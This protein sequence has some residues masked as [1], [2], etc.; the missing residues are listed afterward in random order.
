MDI[1][2]KRFLIGSMAVA[3]A[4]AR[5]MFAAPAGTVCGTPRMKV[6]VLSDIHV[7]DEATQ[8]VFIKALEW[9]RAQGVDAVLVAGD[10][11]DH[12]LVFQLQLVADAW[13]KVFPDNKTPDGR[14]VTQLLEYGNHDVANW[15]EKEFKTPEERAAKMIKFDPKKRWEDAFK[16]GYTPVF[17]KKIEKPN[18]CYTFI[19]AH[20]PGIGGLGDWLKA[21]GKEL[22]PALPFFYFQHSHPKDTCYGPWAWGHDDGASTKALTP[23]PNAIALSGHS[24]YTLTD[25]RTVW[26]GAFTSIGTSSLSYTSLDYNYRENAGPNSYGR[27]PKRTRQMDRLNT[28]E[29]KQ[30]ML[31]TARAEAHAADGPPEHA[32]GQAGDAVH[33][34]RRPHPHRTP[35]VPVRPDAGRRLDPARRQGGRAA[36][37]LREADSRAHG[38]GVPA[39]RV[40]EGGAPAAEGGEGQARAQGPDARGG[41]VPC[42]RDAQQVPRVRVRGASTCRRR[43]PDGRAPARSRSPTC[44]RAFTSAST[45]VRSSASARRASPSTPTAPSWRSKIPQMP[46]CAAARGLINYPPVF[47]AREDRVVVAVRKRTTLRLHP[48]RAPKRINRENGQ[49]PVVPSWIKER[50]KRKMDMPTSAATGLT[51]KDLFDAGLHFGHQTKRWNPKMK[52]YIF[53]KRNG[54]HI[55]DLTQTVTLLDEAAEFIRKTI[56][57]GKKILFVATKK[58]AQEIVKQAAEECGQF[59]MTERWLGGT[60]T[61]S[62][63]IRGSVKRMCQLQAVAKANGGQLSVHKQEASMLRRELTKLEKNLTGVKD[64]SDRPGAV[65]VIDVCRE[66]NAVKEAARLGI[67]LV[68]ITDTNANP[69]PIDYVIPGNDDSVRGIELIVEGIAKVIKAANDEYSRVAAERKAKR[70]EEAK[71][72]EEQQKA[73]RAARKAASAASRKAEAEAKGESALKGVRKAKGGLSTEARQA[74]RAAKE[75]AEAK[76]KEELAAK[77]QEQVAAAEAAVAAAEAPKAE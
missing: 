27:V 54:I 49:V 45:C 29:G 12:G 25:E 70:D 68:A 21:H 72:R 14:L 50:F 67:P 31:F 43:R 18:G 33:R 64:M 76:A 75:A 10:M 15:K 28:Q 38:A 16:E 63:T 58:Q 7:R 6:G 1:T 62:Q 36:V 53:D 4:G 66:L 39:G 61:N 30:G 57:D 11:A 35:R 60:L 69:D 20:W 26:Q 37:R 55:I 17:A 77:R 23:F 47:R 19:G 48:G 8:K 3:A 74:V 44:R 22:D 51:L 59:Y 56:L 73:E 65:F 40:R 34:L 2:R 24:H 41:D 9:Y 52:P 13:F 46:P 5:R 32:G 71:A 42:R